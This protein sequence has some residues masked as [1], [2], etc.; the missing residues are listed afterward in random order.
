MT[1]GPAEYEPQANLALKASAQYGFGTAKRNPLGMR[2]APGPGEYTPFNPN[3]VS[4]RVAFGTSKRPQVDGKHQTPGPGAYNPLRVRDTMTLSATM[5]G[6]R[7]ELSMASAQATPGPATYYGDV[8][9]KPTSC[10]FST[11]ARVTVS[12]SANSSLLNPGPGSYETQAAREPA[13]IFC[14]AGRRSAAKSTGAT[15]SGGSRSR[16]WSG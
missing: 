3:L 13:S 14:L 11:A 1:P 7:D 9:T 4:P 10:G 6:A 8:P 2:L 12:V 15:R 5:G 16:R